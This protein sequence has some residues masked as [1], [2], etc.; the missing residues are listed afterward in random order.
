MTNEQRLFTEVCVSLDTAGK[1]CVEHVNDHL[2][3]ELH[4]LDDMHIRD[5]LH[6]LERLEEWRET[7]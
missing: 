5:L 4:E 2:L 3:V 6:I 7:L 1:L